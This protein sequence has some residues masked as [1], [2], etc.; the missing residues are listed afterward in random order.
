VHE[1]N[2]QRSWNGIYDE[3][4]QKS[5]AA[6]QQLLPARYKKPETQIVVS[7]EIR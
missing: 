7:D 6:L 5:F 2:V 4:V 1:G 3:W